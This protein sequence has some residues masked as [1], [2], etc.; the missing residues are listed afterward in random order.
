[1]RYSC[2]LCQTNQDDEVMIMVKQLN[3]VNR[4]R[5]TFRGNSEACEFYTELA[6]F[7]SVKN[8]PIG[9]TETENKLEEALENTLNSI[10]A[11]VIPSALWS[12]EWPTTS[13]EGLVRLCLTDPNFPGYV[14]KVHDIMKTLT[15]T[16]PQI[17]SS[18]FQQ[19]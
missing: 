7:A 5:L 2:I 12:T 9:P 11:G 1:M 6:R 16:E 4:L 3:R 10:S 19:Q 18:R 8:P 17:L 15:S 13:L 14:R